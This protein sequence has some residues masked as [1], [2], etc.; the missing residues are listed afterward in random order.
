MHSA[1]VRPLLRLLA[2]G[3][4]CLALAGG[5][6][7]CGDDDDQ[8]GAPGG[9]AGAGGAS[10]ASGAGGA[11][12]TAE[13][14]FA[15]GPLAVGYRQ[16]EVRYQPAGGGAERVLPV[17]VW[18]P[19]QG[20]GEGLA[21][22]SVGGIVSLPSTRALA[23][24]APAAGGPFPLAL[25]SHGSG[26][27]GLLAYPYAERF[28]A[29]GWVVAAPSHVGN[30]ALDEVAGQGA[31]LTQIALDRPRDVTAVLDAFAGGLAGDPLAGAGRT[32]RVFLFGH[33]FGGYTTLTSGGVDVDVAKLR[34]SCEPIGACEALEAPGVAA[35]F[36]AGFGDARIAAVAAQAPALVPF[37]GDGQLAA[38]AV[39]TLLMSGRLDQTTTE[40]ENAGPAWAA[41]DHPDDL[42]VDL[43]QGAHF[44]FITICDDV[45]PEL[46]N[47]LQPGTATDGCGP[48]FTPVAEAV[49]ALAAYVLG[50][51]RWHV[52]GET[53]WAPLLR[54]APLHPSFVVS[55]H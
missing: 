42:R 44:S 24:P 30:T 2:S 35:G 39:P 15:P 41:L 20:G 34:A 9:A 22:Y 4:S 37:Y 50:F 55:T 11:S 19:A 52:L 38:L 40:A 23:A 6:G 47:A 7:A 13:E 27:D 16:I 29:R 53:Q 21:T 33:S 32:D 43:P 17:H 8:P 45:A 46:L 1:H 28:A 14:L 5:A 49:P 12:A 48:S 25:Y 18:Y 51:A 31:P 3:L 26:G 36:E 10:G 54:G